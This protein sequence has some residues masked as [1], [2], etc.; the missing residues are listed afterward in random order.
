MRQLWLCKTLTYLSA[1]SDW[2]TALPWQCGW[3]VD[4]S[5]PR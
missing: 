4:V 1:T 2:A 3:Q 5:W